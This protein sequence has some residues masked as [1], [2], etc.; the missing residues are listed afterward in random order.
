MSQIR[1]VL[2]S[3]AVSAHLPSD[4]NATSV[5]RPSCPTK[6]RTSLP[7]VVSQS[8]AVLSSLAVSAR[9]PSGEKT[10]ALTNRVWTPPSL[11]RAAP[12]AVFQMRAALSQ[13]PVRIL[14]PPLENCTDE[15][16]DCGENVISGLPSC[17]C[18]RWASAP[19]T[20]SSRDPSDENV[21]DQRIIVVVDKSRNA[22]CFS[23]G[24]G[25]SRPAFKSH[26]CKRLSLVVLTPRL[27]SGEMATSVVG[28][29]LGG[30]ARST[31]PRARSHNRTTLSPAA[32]NARVPSAE[33]AKL[34]T[35]S[36]C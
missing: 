32:V 21:A 4:E 26:K 12:L 3:E 22:P 18:H 29:V 20:V 35:E 11:M 25:I 36:G 14:T 23:P 9:V 27:P 15:T 8:R 33:M 24:D 5:T 16:A 2:S 34:V 17:A 31:S 10:L 7:V 30:S 28:A 19:P 6:L 1:A 13:L